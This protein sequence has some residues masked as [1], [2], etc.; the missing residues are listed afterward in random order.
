MAIG[1]G[2]AFDKG[3]RTMRNKKHNPKTVH[4]PLGKYSH[5]IEVAPEARWLYA[6]GQVGITAK[7][8]LVRGFKAQ[9]DRAYR[10]MIAVLKA[11]D[12]GVGDLVM[13]TVYLTRPEDIPAY[14]EVRDRHLGRARPASTLVVI[15]QL[16]SPEL[17]IEVEG[18]AAKG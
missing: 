9:C 4:R 18:R 12:M 11:A 15:S 7:G 8:K 6:A 10:N 13:V 1:A 2:E 3:R 17:L 14:R 5:G 16:A